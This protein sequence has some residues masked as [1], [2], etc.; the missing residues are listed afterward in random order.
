MTTM[1]IFEEY[2]AETNTDSIRRAI[3]QHL[4]QFGFNEA[5]F[6]KIFHVT[7]GA[8]NMRVAPEGFNFEYANLNK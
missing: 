5:E 8:T 7:D 1:L 2:T 6:N 4:A 3:I